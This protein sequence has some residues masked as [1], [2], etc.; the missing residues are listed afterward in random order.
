MPGKTGGAFPPE[1]I[2]SP[3][4]I[5]GRVPENPGAIIVRLQLFFIAG[6][7][8]PD[9]S[10]R[11]SVP[12]SLLRFQRQRRASIPAVGMAASIVFDPRVLV[13][14]HLPIASAFTNTAFGVEYLGRELSA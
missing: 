12:P 14:L 13:L 8:V 5:C 7:L 10:G 6:T 3:T 4:R 1:P 2:A 11:I 9:T